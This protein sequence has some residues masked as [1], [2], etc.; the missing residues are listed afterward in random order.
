MMCSTVRV[1]YNIIVCRFVVNKFS[2]GKLEVNERPFVKKF[3]RLFQKHN[4]VHHMVSF[5]FDHGSLFHVFSHIVRIH[6]TAIDAHRQKTL[7][8]FNPKRTVN[9]CGTHSITQPG[10]TKKSA[11][12]ITGQSMTKYWKKRVRCRV[13]FHTCTK[14]FTGNSANE[15]QRCRILKMT[16]EIF[17]YYPLASEQ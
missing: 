6:G 11:P 7:Q 9:V 13:V 15:S 17:V 5:G 1:D 3:A 8:Y 16:V 4:Y 2:K 14:F 12:A 10:L